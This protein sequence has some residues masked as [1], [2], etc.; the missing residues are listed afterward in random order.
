MRESRSRTG[1]W[2]PPTARS[3][4]RLSRAA[5]NDLIAFDNGDP[6]FL[7]VTKTLPGGD[8]PVWTAMH[9]SLPRKLVVP[10]AVTMLLLM[11]LATCINLIPLY[12]YGTPETKTIC[13]G[14]IGF[15]LLYFGLAIILTSVWVLALLIGAGCSQRKPIAPPFL[16]PCTCGRN[17][18]HRGR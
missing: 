17:I 10:G 9:G 18:L 3:A 2:W 14:Y 13:A 16:L 12:L 15:V 7:D 8:S 11:T 5:W 6:Y 1:C 4:Q